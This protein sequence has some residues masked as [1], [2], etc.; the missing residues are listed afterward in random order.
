MAAFDELVTKAKELADTVGRAT[1]ELVDDSRQKLQELRLSSEL[2]D[3]YER[4]GSV[5]YDSIKSG[6]ENRA[7]VDLVVSEIDIIHQSLEALRT[8]AAPAPAEKYCAQCGATN[9]SDAFFC[10]RCGAPLTTPE[11]EETVAEEVPE[12]A[13]TAEETPEPAPE[14]TAEG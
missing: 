12:A 5:M 8:K 10:S 2:K 13:E 3:A 11:A 9:G 14:E 6:E 4:L 7:L 1:G